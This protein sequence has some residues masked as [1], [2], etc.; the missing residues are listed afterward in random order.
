MDDIFIEDE[1]NTESEDTE[2]DDGD[3]GISDDD[4]ES[5]LGEDPENLDLDEED[6]LGLDSIDA[7][8]ENEIGEIEDQLPEKGKEEARGNKGVYFSNTDRGR[9]AQ[10]AYDN[11]RKITNTLGKI[12]GKTSIKISRGVEKIANYDEEI[13]F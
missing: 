2:E 3:Y 9:E 11:M 4:W 1:Y 10:K 12:A 5:A 8:L 6:D 13:D 7:E